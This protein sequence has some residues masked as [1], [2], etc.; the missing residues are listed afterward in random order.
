VNRRLPPLTLACAAAILG[1]WVAVALALR[2]EP[3]RTIPAAVL[4]RFGAADGAHLAA[5]RLVTSQ[6]L[7]VY[8]LHMLFNVAA[9]ALLGWA[10]E[11]AAGSWRFGL[12][13]LLA[14]VA[15]QWVSIAT[16]P[17]LVTCGA[18]Q[19]MMGVAG[20]WLTSRE[21]A[22]APRW[23]TASA[24]AVVIVQLLLDVVAVRHIKLPHA[25]AFFAGAIVNAGTTALAGRRRRR[26]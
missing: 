6:L 26:A 5:W 13:F 20:A 1:A 10:Y 25:A 19:A 12:T 15:G 22:D 24:F 23:M 9:I 18:S 4:L 11:R 16:T 7:H 17:Q 14:G 2:Q 8:A 21:R 3:W